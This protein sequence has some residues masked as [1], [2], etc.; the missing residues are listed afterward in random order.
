MWHRQHTPPAL[1][2]QNLVGLFPGSRRRE[3][4]QLFPIMLEAAR[5]LHAQRPGLRFVASAASPALAEVMREMSGRLSVT[6][7][8]V[9]TGTAPQL[10]RQCSAGVVAS[11]TATLEAAILGLP[12][13]LAY[14]VAWPT[15]AVGKRLIRVPWLGIVNILAGRQIVR[16]FVQSACAPGNLSAELLDL[17]ENAERRR[18]LAG[19]LAQVV[20]SLGEGDAYSRAAEAVAG[21]LSPGAPSS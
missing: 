10:M 13:C 17:L 21:A 5:L 6:N 16:E 9:Q 20:A 14:K 7:L 15:Y 1:R 8:E 18:R 11:G 12:Y 4:S 3:I 2:E 19:E